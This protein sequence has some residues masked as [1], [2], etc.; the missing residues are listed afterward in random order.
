MADRPINALPETTTVGDNDYILLEQDNTAKKVNGRNWKKYFEANLLGVAVNVISPNVQP[1]ASYNTATRVITLNLPS[2][3]YIDKVE[4]T[5]TS[6]LVDTYTITTKLGFTATFEVT[7]AKSISSIELISGTHAAGTYDTYRISFNDGSHIDYVVYNGANGTG[8]PG[9]STPQSDSG[10]GVAGTSTDFA[11]EDHRHALNTDS[12]APADLGTASAG[13]ASTYAKRDHVHKMP[14][15]DDVG[16]LA[17]LGDTGNLNPVTDLN[18]FMTGIGLFNDAGGTTIDNF[19]YT[20]TETQW[21]MIVTAGNGT[22]TAIQVGY[23][24]QGI[25]QPRSRHLVSGTWSGWSSL[26]TSATAL[27]G[28]VPVANGGTYANN[29]ADARTN[30]GITPAN[31]GA[32]S[33]ADFVV[34]SVSIGSITTSAAYKAVTKSAA[35]SGYTPLAIAGWN[36]SNTYISCSELRLSGTD[37]KAT[38]RNVGGTE[39]TFSPSVNVLYMKA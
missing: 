6:G 24:L 12:T 29:A 13:S 10:T 26:K 33:S 8:A 25:I 18:D 22:D 19:P 27:N 28:M 2:A 14:S 35:K 38:F 31:I 32:L 17:K 11:R 34:E 4:K 37:I 39:S 3:D 30:L 5:S 21:A 23:D 15:A 36:C 9:T 1:S 16:A 20:S 7:N